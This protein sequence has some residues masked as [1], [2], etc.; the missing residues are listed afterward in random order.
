MAR[1]S[2]DVDQLVQTETDE[3]VGR[4]DQ[5]VLRAV[6]KQVL[7]ELH[8]DLLGREVGAIQ[9]PMESGRPLLDLAFCLDRPPVAVVVE[10]AVFVGAHQKNAVD[11]CIQH[12]VDDVVHEFGS[13]TWSSLLTAEKREWLVRKERLNLVVHWSAD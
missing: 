7:L 10:V 2:V 1:L 8:V 3:E 11:M 9:V 12:C 5:E 4:H 13:S 6:R